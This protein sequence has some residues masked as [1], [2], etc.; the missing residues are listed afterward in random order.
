MPSVYLLL[1]YQLASLSALEA[2]HAAIIM[3]KQCGARGRFSFEVAI[4]Q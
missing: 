3:A 2:H 1:A 4:A